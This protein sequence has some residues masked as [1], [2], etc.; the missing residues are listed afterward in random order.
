VTTTGETNTR[1][2]FARWNNHEVDM[3]NSK[4][5]KVL[6]NAALQWLQNW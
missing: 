5:D 6:R 3:P 4:N 2:P 1:N